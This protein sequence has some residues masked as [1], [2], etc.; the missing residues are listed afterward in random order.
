MYPKFLYRPCPILFSK[1][2]PFSMGGGIVAV[3]AYF[4][5]RS[6]ATRIFTS[7]F[8]YFIFKI[9]CKHTF[10]ENTIMILKVELTVFTTLRH[11][12]LPLETLFSSL[13]FFT[14]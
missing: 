5:L 6:T 14:F 8:Y 1:S 7:S 9:Q 4:V 12:R 13:I 2:L 11:K 3:L 10:A